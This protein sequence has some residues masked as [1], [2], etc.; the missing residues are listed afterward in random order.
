MS[1][2]HI[3]AFGSLCRGEIDIHSD[4]DVL[5]L[6]ESYDPSIDQ[7][8]FSIYSYGR[9]AKMWHE[10]NPFAWHLHLES[11]LLFSS[12][13][14][15][16]LA[17]L[18]SP[19]KYISGKIDCEKF[20]D[21]FKKSHQEVIGPTRSKIFEASNMFLALRNFATCYSLSKD[22]PTFSRNSCQ[23][24]GADSAQISADLFEVLQRAR[25]LSTRGTGSLLTSD[26][27]TLIRQE[28]PGI[29]KWMNT[30]L[31]TLP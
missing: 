31:K 16:Y 28:S 8:T 1:K 7:N 9:I 21:I 2:R 19:S 20:K 24:L 11:K 27:Y 25:I 3:Y 29:S 6:T 26:D 30:L 22:K 13:N 12:D 10:G 23:Q 14:T 17:N 15:D 4:T 18:G 5:V